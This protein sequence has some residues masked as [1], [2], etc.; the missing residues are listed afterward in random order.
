MSEL[1]TFIDSD[2][3]TND[4]AFTL[5][6]LDNG[7]IRH[8][9][10]Y[11]Y[12]ATRCAE[13]KRQYER[14]KSAVDM[15]EAKLDAEHRVVLKEENPKTT[16]AQ[17]KSAVMMDRRWSSAQARLV[18]AQYIY[19]LT[20]IAVT[21]FDQRKD[22]MLEVARD[23]RKEREGQLRVG[24]ITEGSAPSPAAPAGSKSELMDKVRA[25][26]GIVKNPDAKQEEFE[27]IP[28]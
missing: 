17:I 9:S 4:V 18:D 28:Y 7:M 20:R 23:R 19:E 24:S 14:M 22:M 16:E 21:S 27:D 10:L 26:M 3:L 12:Y 6:D 11:A 8:A 13:A 5:E 15:L 2:Q 25:K 1:K